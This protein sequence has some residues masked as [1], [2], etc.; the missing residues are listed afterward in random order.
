MND[1]KFIRR[2]CNTME[3]YNVIDEVRTTNF[4]DNP[5]AVSTF[6]K[7]FDNK[8]IHYQI[9]QVILERLS[10]EGYEG[11]NVDCKK[12]ISSYF[13]T[14][15]GAVNRD[16]VKDYYLLLKDPNKVRQRRAFLQC[17]MS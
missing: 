14:K 17:V 11:N 6:I 3:F 4:K 1:K 9:T 15:S 2:A 10:I 5:Q 12:A 13:R 7:S 16:K 8:Y